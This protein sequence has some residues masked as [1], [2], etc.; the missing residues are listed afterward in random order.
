MDRVAVSLDNAEPKVGVVA[1]VGE[2]DAY[3]AGR[4]ANELALLVDAGLH[5]VVDLTEATF[6]D[7]QTLS[8][9]LGARHDAEEG[10]LGF[11]LVLRADDATQVHRILEMTGLISAFVIEPTLERALAAARARR[12]APDRLR[13]A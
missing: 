2:H 7:S 1:L 6:V 11:A 13:V 8:V 4:V 9:L 10:S 5:V 12:V 3:T